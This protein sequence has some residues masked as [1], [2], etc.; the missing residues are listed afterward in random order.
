M[1]QEE[2]IANGLGESGSF[3]E[4]NVLGGI[5]LMNPFPTGNQVMLIH[6]LAKT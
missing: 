2:D 6:L 5:V 1:P 4:R 3:A